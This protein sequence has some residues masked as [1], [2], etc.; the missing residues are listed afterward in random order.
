LFENSR[1]FHVE[2]SNLLIFIFEKIS[3]NLK[4]R[5][6]ERIEICRRTKIMQIFKDRVSHI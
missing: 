3:D 4:R 2:K 5:A 1:N 6:K